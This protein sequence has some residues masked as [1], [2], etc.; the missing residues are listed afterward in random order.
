MVPNYQ[1][2]QLN[3]QW[4]VQSKQ[5]ELYQL[6]NTGLIIMYICKG[7]NM[8]RRDLPDIYT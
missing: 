4:L 5:G 7:Y 3:Y 8:V 1:K 2:I 6:A